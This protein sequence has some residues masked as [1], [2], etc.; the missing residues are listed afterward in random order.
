MSTSRRAVPLTL[1]VVGGVFLFGAVLAGYVRD[2]LVDS[3][4]FAAR[5]AA[6]FGSDEVV[7][8]AGGQIV[9]QLVATEPDL[10]TF[11]PLLETVVASTL[12]SDVTSGVVKAAVADVHRSVFAGDDT[13]TLL[14]S[15]L[16]LVAK[17]QLTALDP[18]IGALIPD[19]L[20]DALIEVNADPVLVDAVQLGEDLTTLAAV[21][22]LVA[23]AAFVAAVW[24]AA[25]PR[26]AVVACG[27]AAIVVAVAVVVVEALVRGAVVAEHGEVA[28]FVWDAFAA[29]LG[30]W[31]LALA[32]LGGVV[33]AVAL[34]G[35]GRLDVGVVGGHLRALAGAPEGRPGRA[36]WGGSVVLVGVLL[37]TEWRAVVQVAVGVV[38]AAM[39]VLGGRELLVAL[40]PAAA[41]PRESRAGDAGEADEGQPVRLAAT[42]A[43]VV[44]AIAA[45]AAVWWSGT[46]D[47]DAA[48]V[49]VGCNGSILLCGRTLES[50]TMAATHNSNAAAEDGYL[51][52]YQTVGIV[53]QLDDGVRAL[54]IDVY[55]GLETDTGIVV[56][57]RAPVSAGHRGELVQEAGEAA[58]AAAEEIAARHRDTGGERE[59]YLCH[60]FCEIGAGP[61]VSELTRVREWLEAHPR[62][63]VVFIIQDEGPQPDDI[64][65]AF[66]DSGMIDVVYTPAGDG[67]WPTL[68]EMIDSGR[69]VLVTAENVSG[70]GHDWYLD[71]F[72]VVQDTPFSFATVDEFTCELFRG[73]ADSPLFLV[74][75]WLSPVAASKADVANEAEVLRARIEQCAD[76]GTPTMIA[77]DF[78]DRGDLLEIVDELNGLG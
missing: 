42:V 34:L 75:H 19:D 14:L 22:P 18:E 4:E 45:A 8:V 44:V 30:T 37:I 63:V 46:D 21:L 64:A 10:Q 65:E 5:A 25:D 32:A 33:V 38:G 43:G 56:T 48:D 58:V 53:P 41:R 72:E 47:V 11:R 70:G 3:D 9:D 29:D 49:D 7:D 77:V 26:R 16:L 54:L 12:R 24:V 76:R 74:N 35:V 69:R 23:M 2:T 1:V 39:V 50:V 73:R 55:W 60:A 78:H 52:G 15:D 40:V 67:E 68:G 36:V 62:E 61:F 27:V 6:P 31:A 71:A 20:T 13:V 51:N 59:L 28:G 57:D 17:S 66:E